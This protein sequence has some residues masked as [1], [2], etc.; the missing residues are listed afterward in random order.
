MFPAMLQFRLFEAPHAAAMLSWRYPAPYEIYNAPEGNIEAATRNL[1]RPELH[2]LAVLNEHDEMIAYRCFG[3]D[4]QVPGG[5][6]SE[7]AL[8]LAG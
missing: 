6:Y 4:A 3:P 1:V 7:E 8:D 2:Y 5:D